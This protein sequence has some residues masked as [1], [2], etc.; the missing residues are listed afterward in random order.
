MMMLLSSLTGICVFMPPFGRIKYDPGTLISLLVYVLS[1]ILMIVLARRNQADEIQRSLLA[2]IVASSSDAVV[3][4]NLQ[5][6][7]TSWNPEAEKLFGYTAAE[8]IG[9]PM[10]VVFPPD[11]IAEE[12]EFLAKIAR[13]ERLIRYETVR[14]RRDGTP[15]DVSVTLS[16]IYDRRGRIVGASKIAH[17]ITHRKALEDGLVR[18]NMQLTATMEELKR[19]N[20]ELEEF[21]YIASHDLK[22]PLRGIHNYVSFL[23]EDYASRLDD[24]GRSYLDRM[25][26]LAERMTALIETLLTYSR[27]GSAPLAMEQ[28]NIDALVDE[29]VADIQPT[30]TASGVELRRNGRLPVVRG[31]APRLGEVFQ[32]LIVNAVKYNDKAEKWVEIGCKTGCTPVVY[33]VSDNGIGIPVQHR[34]SVFRIFKRLHEQSKYGGGSGAGLTIVRKIIERHGGRIWLE[35]TLGEGTTFFFTLEEG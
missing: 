6:I 27:L 32:N 20:K 30:L 26:R 23:R 1:S 7:I 14:L 34:E 22:E 21:A 4:K 8:A 5:G 9:L 31:N 2:A 19:S 15:I 29:V 10:T 28:V 16:P 18:S 17:N 11:R 24:E 25:Q 3:S 33:Y 35:S 12:A 13:G